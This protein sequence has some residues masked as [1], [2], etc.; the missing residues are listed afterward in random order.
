[1]DKLIKMFIVGAVV[2]MQERIL[3]N[4]F[5]NF[6]LVDLGDVFITQAGYGPEDWDNVVN[7]KSFAGN[8]M[9]IAHV[10]RSFLN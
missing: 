8:D 5:P 4:P 3:R 9:V 7:V 10:S 1:M 2:D 6:N